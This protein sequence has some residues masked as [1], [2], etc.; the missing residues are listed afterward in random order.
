MVN[1]NRKDPDGAVTQDVVASP[2]TSTSVIDHRPGKIQT[3][4][5]HPV[6]HVEIVESTV[7]HELRRK[8]V[9]AGELLDGGVSHEVVGVGL[10][11]SRIVSSVI[12][13]LDLVAL[14]FIQKHVDY[15]RDRRDR[16]LHKKTP[17]HIHPACTH[18]IEDVLDLGPQQDRLAPIDTGLH[19]NLVLGEVVVV[20]LSIHQVLDNGLG[21][22]DR[23]HVRSK[24]H[25]L[26]SAM[27]TRKAPVAA[28]LVCCAVIARTGHVK[29]E[30]SSLTGCQIYGNARA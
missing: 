25:P 24:T 7:V 4:A 18:A 19:M 20:V 27:R 26:P 10:V 29:L 9:L 12:H 16:T 13:P 21:T 15:L 3:L 22:S 2:K 30:G 1:Q 8:V 6:R 11:G 14:G 23:L 5:P 28:D 17:F